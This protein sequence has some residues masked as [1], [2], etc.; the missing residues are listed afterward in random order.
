MPLSHTQ[1]DGKT[2]QV[3]TGNPDFS[4]VFTEN[5]S[6][7]QSPDCGAVFMLKAVLTRIKLRSM[8]KNC[9]TGHEGG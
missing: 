3:H 1:E 6:A 4:F 9:K 5:K 2:N 8:S 7:A